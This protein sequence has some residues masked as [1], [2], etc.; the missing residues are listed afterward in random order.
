MTN[1]KEQFFLQYASLGLAELI[2]RYRT[3][4]EPKKGD[5]FN[6]EGITY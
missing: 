1:F 6:V 4:Y 5:R 3:Q 2:A